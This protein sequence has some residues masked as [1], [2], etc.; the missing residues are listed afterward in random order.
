[1]NYSQPV[2]TVVTPGEDGTIEDVRHG[3]R[4]NILPLQ[5]QETQDTSTVTTDEVRLIRGGSGY[6]YI[7][8]NGYSNVYVMAPEKHKLKLVRKITISEQGLQN[9][10]FNQRDPYVMLLNRGTNTT[11]RITENGIQQE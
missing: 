1:M 4:F 11:Y 3:L 8:A 7:T 10:A 9:P 6:Y 5:F 2:E